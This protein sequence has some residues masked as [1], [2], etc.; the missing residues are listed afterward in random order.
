M[1]YCTPEGCVFQCPENTFV[2]G[3]NCAIHCADMYIYNKSCIHTCPNTHPLVEERIRIISLQFHKYKFCRDLCPPQNFQLNGKCIKSCQDDHKFVEN[4]KCLDKCS[5]TSHVH[6]N[7]TLGSRLLGIECLSTCSGE[8]PFHRNQSCV[9][10]CDEAEVVVDSRCLQECPEKKRNE[11]DLNLCVVLG[12]CRNNWPDQIY[13]SE[14][15]PENFYSYNMTCRNNCPLDAS[16]IWN[17]TCVSACPRA[18]S[19][20]KWVYAWEYSGYE[21]HL[22]CTDKCPRK[23]D[24]L[25]L[26]CVPHCKH[27]TVSYNNMCVKQCPQNT[28]ISD[29]RNTKEISCVTECAKYVHQGKCVDVC[30]GFNINKSCVDSCPSNYTFIYQSSCESACPNNTCLTEDGIHCTDECSFDPRDNT[31]ADV[32]PTHTPYKRENICVSECKVNEV[33][34]DK[35]NCINVTECKRPV[36]SHGRCQDECPAGYLYMAHNYLIDGDYR[37]YYPDHTYSYNADDLKNDPCVTVISAYL[38]T[39]V[40]G[41]LTLMYGLWFVCFISTKQIKYLKTRKDQAIREQAEVTKEPAAIQD[42][43]GETFEDTEDVRLIDVSTE[44][45]ATSQELSTKTFED[46]EDVRLIDV[47]IEN[48]ATNHDLPGGTFVD[49]EEVQ[50]IETAIDDNA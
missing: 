7:I 44:E 40:F 10:M 4:G 17:G 12:K 24:M 14:S 36:L 29:N 15:C 45:Q 25:S 3:S 47:T 1:P 43:S 34:D 33:L 9:S 21:K 22:E 39:M 5:T 41:L 31:L 11:L 2:N 20:K 28:Y 32:C 42:F 35:N 16:Y 18:Y 46:N 37:S 30:P 38:P 48:Q 50:L 23:T 49:D 27:G 13:C 19:Y 8:Y 6:R 26:E